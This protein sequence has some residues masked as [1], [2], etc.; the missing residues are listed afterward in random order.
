MF[1][2][3]TSGVKLN[4]MLTSW[5]PVSSGVRQE[6][7]ISPT[8]FAFFI[9]DLAEGIKRLHKGIKLNNL[10]ICCLLYAHYIML[11]SETEEDMQAMLDF[12][13]EGC[14]KR[15]LRI[16]YA[17]SNFCAFSKQKERM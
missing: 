1:L 17:K 6:D 16:N 14:R 11:M 13:H 3:T 5:F 12:V 8:I 9:N 7:S 15:R 10:E 4:G 2:D